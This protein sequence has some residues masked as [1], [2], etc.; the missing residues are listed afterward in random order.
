MNKKM[1]LQLL[2]LRNVTQFRSIPRIRS[3]FRGKL[4]LLLRHPLAALML[5]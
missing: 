1:L 5:S 4:R 3:G 2:E